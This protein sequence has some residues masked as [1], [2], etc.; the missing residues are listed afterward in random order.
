[1]EFHYDLLHDPIR[2]VFAVDC[3]RVG[4]LLTC[5]AIFLEPLIQSRVLV[6]ECD[7]AR[8]LVELPPNLLNQPKAFAG[9]AVELPITDE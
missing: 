4:D 3:T 7:T 2:T 6:L 5:G 1:M 9:W 8:L